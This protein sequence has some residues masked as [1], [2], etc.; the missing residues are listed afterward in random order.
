MGQPGK[1]A[2]QA[3]YISNWLLISSGSQARSPKAKG[4]S[5][6]LFLLRKDGRVSRGMRTAVFRAPSDSSSPQSCLVCR[7]ISIQRPQPQRVLTSSTENP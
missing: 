2:C 4:I 5:N 3:G 7:E 6:P 1:Q